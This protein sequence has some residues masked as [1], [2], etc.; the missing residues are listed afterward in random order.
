MVFNTDVCPI[1]HHFR[2]TTTYSFKLSTKN[3]GQ[4]SEDG[5]MVTIDGL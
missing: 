1:F 5:D 2:D 4:T 3:C